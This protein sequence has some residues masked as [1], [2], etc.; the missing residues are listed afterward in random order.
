MSRANSEKFKAPNTSRSVSLD[1]TTEL[2]EN[3]G[4]SAIDLGVTKTRSPVLSAGLLIFTIIVLIIPLSGSPVKF[5]L[6]LSFTFIYLLLYTLNHST[7]NKKNNNLEGFAEATSHD[8]FFIVNTNA[9]Q[10]R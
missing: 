6:S 4:R 3:R 2:L 5:V 8:I 7:A 9:K 1:R 10:I